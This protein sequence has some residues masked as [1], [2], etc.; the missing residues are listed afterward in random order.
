M[1]WM[2][3]KPGPYIG[4]QC[5]C[6]KFSD[7]ILKSFNPI[8][9]AAVASLFSDCSFLLSVVDQSG[10]A[11]Q[12]AHECIC[13]HVQVSVT[14]ILLLHCL[15]RSPDDFS[16]LAVCMRD[17]TV[18]L[19]DTRQLQARKQDL[20]GWHSQMELIFNCFC[21]RIQREILRKEQDVL[22]FHFYGIT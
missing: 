22:N 10:V 13:F 4:A 17:S 3:R 18:L 21:V 14:Y 6:E 8:V 7:T 12:A 11:I 16:C 15:H 2:N 9:H 1:Q 19:T 20:C 5:T